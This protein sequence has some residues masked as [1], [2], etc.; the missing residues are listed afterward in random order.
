MNDNDNVDLI[1]LLQGNTALRAV[2]ED[3]AISSC[4]VQHPGALCCTSTSISKDAFNGVAVVNMRTVARLADDPQMKQS[5]TIDDLAGLATQAMC[6]SASDVCREHARSLNRAVLGTERL[7]MHKELCHTLQCGK[8][9]QVLNHSVS[10]FGHENF[11]L[12]LKDP[13]TGRRYV[14]GNWVGG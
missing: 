9:V 3:P 5:L 13:V 8:I 14:W 12:L 6:N 4:V 11:K 7:K 10:E 2:H 1:A